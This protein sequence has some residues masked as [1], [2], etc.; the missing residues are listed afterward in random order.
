MREVIQNKH[1]L[2][3]KLR[4]QQHLSKMIVLVNI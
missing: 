4:Y 1:E 3:H 2:E